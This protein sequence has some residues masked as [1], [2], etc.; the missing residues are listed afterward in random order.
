MRRRTIL[1]LWAVAVAGGI[2]PARAE[3][4]SPAQVPAGGGLFGLPALMAQQQALQARMGPLLA[5]GRYRDVE[6]LLNA[7][8]GE[9]PAVAAN[10]YN[11]ACVQS[12]QLK[13][14]DAMRS[15]AIAVDKGFA[16]VPMLRL[17]PDLDFLR[18]DPAFRAIEDKAAAQAR[19]LPPG[20]S[21]DIR[22]AVVE[23]SEVGVSATNAVWDMQTGAFRCAVAVRPGGGAPA[24]IKGQGAAGD[25]VNA[26]LKDGTAAGLHGV[27]YDNHDD[28][29]IVL[30]VSEFPGLA[31]IRFGQ[32]F[33][34][35][36]LVNGLQS[37]LIFSLPT[38]GNSSTAVTGGAFWRSMPRV[39][40]VTPGAMA[41]LY[42]QYVS[43]QLYV[44][45]EHQD[46]DPA[47]E[48]GGRGDLY[49]ANT[50]YVII[51]QGSSGS[52]LPFLKAVA[53][54]VGAFR[55]ETR[56]ALVLSGTLMPA[57]Q[58][59]FR[60]SNRPVQKDEDYLTGRAHPTVF[61]ASVLDVEKMVRAAHGM[62]PE[63]IPP[64]VQLRVLQEDEA[65][66]GIDHFDAAT[67]ERLF[68]T[69]AAVARLACSTRHTRRMV[70]SADGSRDPN[71]RP[72]A[73]RWVVLRGDAAAISIKPMNPEGSV[74]E[75]LVPFHER[76]PVEP[77]AALTS[78]RVDIGVFVHNGV[79]Y[80][81]P[82]FVSI[83][84]PAHERRVYGAGGR[85]VSVD[86]ASGAASG[87]YADPALQWAKD[88]RDE[89]RY[90]D[91]GRLLGWTR[92][93]GSAAEEFTADG[94]LVI[95][96]DGEGRPLRARLMRYAGEQKEPRTPPVIRLVPGDTVRYG[97]ASAGDGVGRIVS[98]VTEAAPVAR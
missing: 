98:R 10:Y 67:R 43:N 47:G 60:M 55:P 12:R 5:Q 35:A 81:A 95:E 32:D 59:I 36:R 16:S 11:L 88:W 75:I 26:W 86:Y 78:S 63:T 89:Y 13:R 93:R 82:G 73:Y 44:Y 57:V 54:T 28:G 24:P 97:Y 1:A 25:L 42:N 34:Q 77:G 2:L 38:L 45:P 48:G 18:D 40:M 90:D 29:H 74:A 19:A 17:D 96:K 91:A 41:V 50:P 53:C 27:L 94:A 23:G 68:D 61:D 79:C 6:Q 22:A 83:D 9:N 65:T 62:A 92:H 66:A 39:A 21:T 80:S 51:S 72:L 7:A 30:D 46:H 64:I 69:P 84:F 49:P 76:R 52:D 58:M 20:A 33:R 8:I 56:R 3:E 4:G 14:A 71:G 37:S 15:L 31:R 87:G 70:V 85:I